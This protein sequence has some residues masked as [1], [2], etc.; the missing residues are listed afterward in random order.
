MRYMIG[1]LSALI[2]IIGATTANSLYMSSVTG[3]AI[4]YVEDALAAGEADDES[5]TVQ[6]ALA[7]DRYWDE[8]RS[9]LESVLMHAELDDILVTIS[10]FVSA[11]ENGDRENFRANGRLLYVQLRHLA[12][13]ERLRV[14]NI[15]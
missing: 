7:L 11:A 4:A 6:A 5:A 15:L 2:V 14:G 13:L 10:D 3:K 8:R 9:Y 12:E 1:A